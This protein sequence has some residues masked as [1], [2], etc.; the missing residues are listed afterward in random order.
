M[1]GDH[2]RIQGAYKIKRRFVY[3]NSFGIKI[4]NSRVSQLKG[5]CINNFSHR[6]SRELINGLNTQ[7][8]DDEWWVQFTDKSMVMIGEYLT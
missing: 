6:S 1:F 2:Q 3:Q 7:L 4:W 8:L 5:L